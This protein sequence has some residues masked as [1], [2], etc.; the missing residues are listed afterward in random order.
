MFSVKSMDRFL[1]ENCSMGSPES[2][3]GD[4]E[5]LANCMPLSEVRLNLG[6]NVLKDVLMTER[7]TTQS[8]DCEKEDMDKVKRPMNAFM[9]WS[10]I[11]R[12]KMTSLYPDMHNAEISRRLGKK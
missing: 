6:G 4:L 10:Q 1:A 2:Q 8:P 3:D 9:V 5:M 12:K 11:E 7:E